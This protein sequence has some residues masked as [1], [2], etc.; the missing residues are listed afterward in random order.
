MKELI[1]E[2]LLKLVAYYLAVDPD[3]CILISFLQLPL[4]GVS[5]AH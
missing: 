2:T 1:E 4:F 3:C 5:H